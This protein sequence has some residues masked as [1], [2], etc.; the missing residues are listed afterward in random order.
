MTRLALLAGQGDLPGVLANALSG[1]DWFAC[2]LDGHAPQAVGQSRPFQVERLGSFIED[3]HA[4]GVTEVCFAGA[5]ARPTLDPAAI[6]DATQ[7]LM[8]RISAAMT[9]GDDAALR[10]VVT[11]FEEA[12]FRI[13]GA[14]D[15]APSLLDLPLAGEL[16]DAQMSDISRAAE[17]HAGLAPL[18]VGQACVVAS[19]QVLAIEALPGTDWML[20]SL[21]LPGPRAPAPPGGTFDFLG[22]AA[23]WLSGG[24][25]PDGLPAFDR[26]KG[27]IF[28]KA[29]KPGQDLR[30]DLP[31]IGPDT[32]TRCA[33]A[34]LDGLVL[35]KGRVLVLDRD[36]VAA[37]LM[38]TGLF[39]AA[40][41]P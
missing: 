3:L 35:E 1:R 25:Q 24:A 34:G 10:S 36:G 15:I 21:A 17:I 33:A 27:G 20:A 19:G 6:D 16:S 26:P 38:A 9:S 13:V 37:R 40:W 31:T 23:D 14:A 11:I 41:S 39:L 22:G 5:I 28:F 4:S 32:V 18:D 7:P 30:V 8:A 29:S 12:G 2:H